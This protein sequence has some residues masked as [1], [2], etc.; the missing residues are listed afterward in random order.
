MDKKKA[1]RLA[2]VLCTLAALGTLGFPKTRQDCAIRYV[3]VPNGAAGLIVRYVFE[4]IM[5]PLTIEPVPFE[6]YALYDCCASATQYALGSGRLDMAVMCPDAARALVAKDRRFEIAGPVMMNSD[7]LIIRPGG[8]PG[9]IEIAISQKRTFQRQM[10]SRRFGERGRPVP[11]LHSAVPFAYARG[12]VRAAVVDITKAFSLE[13]TLSAAA[14]S[15]RDICT[16]VLVIKK[17]LRGADQYRRF[18][19]IYGRTVRQ[20]D[21]A[22]RLLRL[23]QTYVSANITMGDVEKWKRMNVQFTDPQNFHRQRQ[24]GP[25]S[26]SISKN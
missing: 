11:M 24:D 15:G 17:S 4:K 18:M 22:A 25:E 7:I 20:M 23:L 10:V 2:A 12:L 19:E 16:Y 21:D 8:D 5:E 13:G 6:A 26:G 1:W 9:K 14:Q 3:G